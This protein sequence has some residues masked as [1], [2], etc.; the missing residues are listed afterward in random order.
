MRRRLPAMSSMRGQMRADR[1]GDVKDLDEP[2][3]AVPRRHGGSSWRGRQFPYGLASDWDAS[4]WGWASD[5]APTGSQIAQSGT[6]NGA[7]PIE[8]D[9]M[10]AGLVLVLNPDVDANV[11]V[12]AAGDRDWSFHHAAE[13]F[14]A[15][16]DLQNVRRGRP[17]G[18]RAGDDR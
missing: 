13:L 7:Q 12:G 2:L 10:E 3:E 18:S 8:V 5:H 17:A 1:A 15:I 16:G 11:E 4:A 14:A 9:G 6:S